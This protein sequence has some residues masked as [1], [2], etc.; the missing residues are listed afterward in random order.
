MWLVQDVQDFESFMCYIITGSI[1]MFPFEICK[2][3]LRVKSCE[4]HARNNGQE[5]SHFPLKGYQIAMNLFCC[6]S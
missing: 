2:V 4:Y 1:S 6:M 3:R 5:L